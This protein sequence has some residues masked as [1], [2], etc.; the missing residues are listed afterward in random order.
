MRQV[1]IYNKKVRNY[2][3]IRSFILVNFTYNILLNMTKNT[4]GTKKEDAM[5]KALQDLSLKKRKRAS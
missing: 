1:M 4:I 2:L 3:N 5:G